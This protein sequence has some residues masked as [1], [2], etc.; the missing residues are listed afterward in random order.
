MHR[1]KYFHKQ[2]W[3]TQFG[4]DYSQTQLEGGLSSAYQEDSIY[5]ADYRYD[6]ES[7]RIAAFWKMGRLWDK[8]SMGFQNRFYF[9]DREAFFGDNNQALYSTRDYSGAGN[10]W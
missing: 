1:W 10:V 9:H 7:R 5:N 6:Q 2:K 8:W 4:F 3:R